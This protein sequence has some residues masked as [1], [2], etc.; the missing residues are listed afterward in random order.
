MTTPTGQAPT[1]TASTTTSTAM[2]GGS[3][4]SV[5]HEGGS[6]TSQSTPAGGE[7]QPTSAQTTGSAESTESSTSESPGAGPGGDATAATTRHG[8]GSR[9]KE[10][11]RRAERN[12]N[13]DFVARDK[14]IFFHGG[15]RSVRLRQ[16]SP[17]L[18]ESA[19]SAFIAPPGWDEVLVAY[20]KSRV[21]VLRGKAGH[22]KT[23]AAIRL[24][25]RGGANPVYHVGSGE[26]AVLAEVLQA[27]DLEER[28]NENLRG[29]G[30]VLDHPAE[31]AAVRASALRGIEAALEIAQAHLV[32]AVGSAEP[33]RDPAFLDFAAELSGAPDRREVLSAHLGRLLDAQRAAELLGRPEIE[34]LVAGDLT[35]D[36]PC[37]G[38]VSL[39]AALADEELT[40]KADVGRV[41]DRRSQQQAVSFEVW[42]AQLPDAKARCHAVALA[43][44]GGAGQEAVTSAARSLHRRLVPRPNLVVSGSAGDEPSDRDPFHRTQSKLLSLL[45]A[46]TRIETV[47]GPFGDAPVRTTEYCEPYLPNA[48][49]RHVWTEYQFHDDLLDWLTELS[50]DSSYQVRILAA[51]ALGSLSLLSFDY[52]CGRILVPWAQSE[53]PNR[54]E[55]VAY[56][57]WV[58]AG[59][60]DLLGSVQELAGGWYADRGEPTCQATAARIHGLGLGALD[61]EAAID[62]LMRLMVVD[63]E[64]VSIAIGE[65]LGDLTAD[66]DAALTQTVLGRLL[67]A[68]ADYRT[69]LT[70]ELAF[71][72][73]AVLNLVEKPS[74]SVDPGGPRASTTVTWPALLELAGTQPV[75]RDRIIGLWRAVLGSARFHNE[76]AGVF[77]A[78]AG[79]AQADPA[80]RDAFL[81]LARAVA[82]TDE[83]CSRVLSRLAATWVSAE[84]LTPLTDMSAA[85]QRVLPRETP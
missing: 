76:A 67:E 68:A 78:W 62:M 6:G 40:G 60:A 13:G 8:E 35:D 33:I 27:G 48:V 61:P 5:G 37:S 17:G 80:Q 34:E 23:A 63:D 51:T 28:E 44:L 56:A 4:P 64:H 85:L 42:F 57:L 11:L 83:R 36:T 19:E 53:R 3:T 7:A 29:A 2:A 43:V 31:F 12:V 55:A 46:R 72:Q 81:R 15:E 59:D 66:G 14:Y 38:V 26:L 77:S 82:Q 45:Q 41:R 65:A 69:A 73:L 39:A 32:I 47:Q 54:R 50:D 74:T 18:V 24:L 52:V 84:N 1:P 79:S 30:F 22:G 20:A 49:L 25:S 21:L 70:A 71:L 10:A 75:A 58:A 16:M 9:R